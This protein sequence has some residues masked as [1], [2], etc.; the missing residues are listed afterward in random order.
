M[1][2]LLSAY[3]CEPS[4]GSEPGVGWNWAIEIEKLGHQV[5]V[6][7]RSNNKAIIEEHWRNNS[8]PENLNFIYYDVPKL[9]SWWKKGARGVR[10]YYFFW[11][12]GA[13]CKAKK[14]HKLNRFDI[15]HHITF[16]VVRQPSFMGA[17]GI[18]FILGPLGGGERAPIALRKGYPF[19]GKVLDCIRDFMNLLIAIDPLMNYTFSKACKIYVKTPESKNVI[20]RSFHIKTEVSIEIGINSHLSEFPVKHM[21]NKVKLL[22]VGRFVYWKGAHL[23]LRAFLMARVTLPYL[24]LTMVGNG[25]EEC[26]LKKIV[27]N[28]VDS[29]DWIS[30]VDQSELSKIYDNHD[31]LLFPSL[32]D[33]SGNVLLESMAKGLPVICL[34]MG[35]PGVIV[36]DTC[37]I[38][39]NIDGLS[40]KQVI[41]HLTQA[42]LDFCSNQEDRIK[43]SKGALDK[44]K[45]MSW[46][47]AVASVY[48]ERGL[49]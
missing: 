46:S 18:P 32:H 37:G 39:V 10:L 45:G 3:A 1:K 2:V 19:R 9:L 8:K 44:A 31:G 49:H 38:S 27:D 21:S 26:Q 25:P 13:Y 33:S 35:G 34:N 28:Q 11:Q 48:N 40:E 43:L 47:A 36:D 41:D 6:I 29:I 14:S 7:T 16:G 15:V 5:W 4:R 30:W 42:I 12:I 17:L 22:Y 24:H 20:P 23:A